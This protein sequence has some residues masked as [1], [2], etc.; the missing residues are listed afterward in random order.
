MLALAS[1][2]AGALRGGRWRSVIRLLRATAIFGL[3]LALSLLARAQSAAP[4]PLKLQIVGGLAG[5]TQFTEHEEPFWTQRLP[6]LSQGRYS[7]DIVPFDRA[8][9]PGAEMLRLMQ[10]G[11]VPFGTVLMGTLAAQYPQYA[12]ADLP[13]LGTHIA[14]T[15]VSVSAFRPYLESMLHQQ[16]GIKLLALY[17]Y[18]AQ[19]LF[20]KDKMDHLSDVRGRRIRVASVGQADWVQALGATAVHT[21]F[22]Q[23]RESLKAGDT[24]CAVTGSLSGHTL[25]LYEV[26]QYLYP[27]PINWGV[28]VFGVNGAVWN[29]LPADLRDLLQR[30]LLRLEESIW[31]AADRDTALGLACNS[32]ASTCTLPSR[33]A[34]TLLRV[35][36][37]DEHY[38]RKIFQSVVLPRWIKRCTHVDCAA[39]WNRTLGPAHS[40][41]ASAQP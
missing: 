3:A 31:K 23:L 36:P 39:L 18:P 12:A 40:I 11:V 17:A 41:Y 15:R 16:H 4:A 32:G 19:V 21:P 34:M 28:A 25:G 8:G 10:L 30:E 14:T 27:L 26:T 1:L 37:E 22:A 33:G 6:Q 13:G 24:D 29:S 7:A 35:A 9:V 38:S 20:C 5:V 2:Q